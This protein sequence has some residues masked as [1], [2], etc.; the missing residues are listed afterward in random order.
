M[1]YLLTCLLF[2]S[3]LAN[4]HLLSCS[5][6][7]VREA[8]VEKDMY[9]NKIEA[10]LRSKEFEIEYLTQDNSSLRDYNKD[11]EKQVVLSIK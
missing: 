6:V 11:L 4:G 10:N 3:L 7:W 1:I 2:F 8:C 9:I 5:R